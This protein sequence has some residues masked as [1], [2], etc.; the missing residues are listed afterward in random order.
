MYSWVQGSLPAS[1][2]PDKI[3][4]I[5]GAM[6]VDLVFLEAG[7]PQNLLR[8]LILILPEDTK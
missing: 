5:M 1:A 7:K 6:T 2:V 8:P 3:T 4:Y